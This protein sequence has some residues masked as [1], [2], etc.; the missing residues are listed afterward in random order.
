MSLLEIIGTV[1]GVIGVT[2]MIRR[3]IWGWPVGLAQVA[4]SAWVFSAAKNYSSALLQIFFFVIQIYGWRHW[5]RGGGSAQ[6]GLRIT[7]MRVEEKGAWLVIG[8]IGAAGW[9]E[10][11]QRL[12][13]AALPHWDAF[14]FIFSL[15]AQW[16]QARK[17]LECWTGWM[18][19]NVVAAPVYW[20]QDLRLYAGLYVVFFGMAVAGHV[21][22]R[23]A[24]KQQATRSPF[25][26]KKAGA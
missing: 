25:P 14:I 11:M 13:D 2:L 17:R 1:L 6:A 21:A 3:N 15:I 5:L 12:T 10:L 24:M 22:W 8:A 7:R 26:Q 20:A 23:R 9:G 19:V 18:I 4:V 16:L